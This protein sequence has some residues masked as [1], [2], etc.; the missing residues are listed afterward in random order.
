MSDNTSNTII[1]FVGMPGSGKSSAVAYLKQKGTPFVNFGQI[2]LDEVTKRGL[3]INPEN[4][5]IVR[6]DLRKTYGMQVCAERSLLTLQSLMSQNNTVGIDGLYSWEEYVF[7]KKHCQNVQII[8]IFAERSLR[9]Q[10]LSTRPI[11]PLTHDEAEKR[12]IAE[13]EHL[14][15]GGPIAMADYIIENNG[16]MEELHEKLENLLTKLQV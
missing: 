13:I 2:I 10:R 9:Y 6:E 4:E 8:H 1:A 3:E 5:R 15:K 14:N 16:T 11:R 12:D 7:L